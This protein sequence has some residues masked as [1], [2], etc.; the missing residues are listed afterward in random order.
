MKRKTI[1]SIMIIFAMALTS[2]LPIVTADS[3][4][5]AI[6][7]WPDEGG[8]NPQN[9]EAT[10]AVTYDTGTGGS[11]GL[12]TDAP[13]KI[14]AIWET[15]EDYYDA[16]SSQEGAQI[17][18]PMVYDG[19]TTVKIFVAIED[20]DGVLPPENS[21]KIDVSWPYNTCCY[22]DPEYGTG[23]IPTS[24]P[25]WDN[26]EPVNDGTWAL[27]YLPAHYTDYYY[28]ICYYNEANDGIDLEGYDYLEW[29]YGEGNLIIKWVEIELY[30]H[31]P[32]GW[33]D[34]HVAVQGPSVD[35]QMNYFEYDMGIG[36]EIDFDY[37]D[38]G[39]KVHIDQWYDYDGNEAFDPTEENYLGKQRPTVRNIGNWDAELGVRF[40]DG[41]FEPENVLFDARIGYS[42]PEASGYNPSIRECQQLDGLLPNVDYYPF[43][44]NNY[45]ELGYD[46]RN[47]VVLKCH[48]YKM[49]FYL[50]PLQWNL[51]EGLYEF[52]IYLF[53]NAPECVPD[54]VEPCPYYEPSPD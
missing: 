25:D 29:A 50:N 51:G 43:P 16:D 36:V 28:Y 18:P 30:Y 26:I 39:T 45:D 9:A 17:D 14:L 1:F 32:A 19:W 7:W 48:T 31:W 35:Q 46:C 21:V 15:G 41:D 5:L 22:L 24:N 27:D 12:G 6:A 42:N 3:G 23:G 10:G 53:V 49:D 13:L 54:Y 2:V 4:N 38:W 47:D 52:P 44:I 33:Y 11:G 8:A 40:G 34:V 37:L 20:P